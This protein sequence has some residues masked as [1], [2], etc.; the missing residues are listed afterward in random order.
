MSESQSFPSF[1]SDKVGQGQQEVLISVLDQQAELASIQRMRSWASGALALRPGERALDIGSG[2]GSEVV[3]MAAAVGADGRAIGVDPN[4]DMVA[5]AASRA[6]GTPAA[7]VEGNAYQLPFPDDSFDAVRCERVFQHLDRPERATAEIARV[8]RPGGR[9][10]IID[11]DWATAIMHPVDPEIVAALMGPRAAQAP[12]RNSGR[13]LRGL[14]TGAGFTVDDIGSEAVIF[15]PAMSAPMYAAQAAAAVAAGIITA[16]QA[17]QAAA[18]L[19]HGIAT[20][21]YLFSVTMY[22][23]VGHLA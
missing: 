13:R 8:L 6:A 14:L 20:G 22:A 2:T 23:V 21:D 19:E 15:D 7:F 10:I 1:H 18:E 5:L 17:D 3:A 12:N 16:A 11:S 4:P 9:A